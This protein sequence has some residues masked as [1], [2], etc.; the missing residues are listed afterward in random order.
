MQAAPEAVNQEIIELLHFSGDRYSHPDSLYGYGIPDLIK[1]VF[2]LR[3]K[4]SPRAGEMTVFPNPTTGDFD[5]IFLDPPGEITIEIIS[6]TG[7]LISRKEYPDFTGNKLN[8]NDLHT[9]EQGIYFLKVI[10]SRGTIV[11]RIIRVKN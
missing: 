10:H 8:I 7:K 1:A 5:L 2:F 3:E 4:H 11:S 6:L 9:V